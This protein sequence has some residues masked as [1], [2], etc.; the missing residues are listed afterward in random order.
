M[1]ILKNKYPAKEHT[2]KVLSHLPKTDNAIIY[3]KGDYTKC[4]HNT[5]CEN[6][7]RQESN[8]FYL[9]GVEKPGFQLVI[10]VATG[11]STLFA[12][13]V[14]EA[15]IMWIGLP[16]PLSSVQEKYDVDQVLYA[17][18]LDSFVEKLNPSTVHVFTEVIDAKAVEKYESKFERDNIKVA[19]EEARMVKTEYEIELL[20]EANRIASE[21]HVELFKGTKAN[22]NE[23]ELHALFA[24]TCHRQGSS[25]LGYNPIVGAGKN[26]AILHYGDNNSEIEKN[27]DL[28]L[29]D[30]GCDYRFYASDITRCYPVGGKFTED[31][32]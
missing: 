24:Y 9:T 8:F 18:E 30:A 25:G 16:A 19:L 2:Q 10:E 32:K 4:R 27:G 21:A 1:S 23:R 14:D 11:K 15:D 12:P 17:S 29:V 5:D 6:T 22:M 26:S 31:S 7:F 3:L 28:I 20:L 13:D